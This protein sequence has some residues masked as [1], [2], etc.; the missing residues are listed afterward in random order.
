MNIH[1]ASP[2]RHIDTSFAN[3]VARRKASESAHMVGGIPDYA[4]ALDYELRS[5]LMQIPHFHSICKKINATLE[6]REIQF[7]NQKALAVGPN[8]FPD[9][10]RMGTDC[11]HRLGIGIPNIFVYTDPTMNAFTYARDDT[12]PMIVLFSGIVER[13]TPGEL[14]C[15]IAHECG[16]IHNQ[17]M[18]FQSVINTILNSAAGSLGTAVLSLAN[19]S[20][21]QFWTRAG[22]VTADRAALICA[23]DPQDA[24]NVNAKLLY[25]GALN[26]A[27][28]V[29][30]DALREQL[31]QTMNNPTKI[32]ELQNDHPS[33]IRRIFADKEFEECDV[34]YRW[35]PELKKPGAVIRSKDE[36]DERCKKLVN[37]LNND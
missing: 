24:F 36:T 12:S 9:I 28:Q 26:N 18:V 21:M 6:T 34:F 2:L 7:F 4:F 30:L 33:A 20:L 5:K 37:I 13:M 35:R 32:F 1:T 8:Q 14:K 11:A 27:S 25:G 19:L 15:V 31:E 23:D 22:E 17:H 16:H 3:Y 29:N 10:Y